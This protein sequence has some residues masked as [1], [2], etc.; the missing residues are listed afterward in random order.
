L[1]LKV[2]FCLKQREYTRMNKLIKIEDYPCGSGKMTRMIENFKEDQKYLVT[3]PMLTEVTRVIEGSKDIE[4]VQPRANDNE[5]RL[6][7]RR[8]S[9]YSVTT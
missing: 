8:H 7:V 5:Q 1:R 2:F 9:F 3:L 6:A 4:F